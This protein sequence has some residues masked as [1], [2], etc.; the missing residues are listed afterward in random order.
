[1]TRKQL[2]TKA[3]LAEEVDRYDEVL[4]SMKKMALLK[5]D[6]TE[7]ERKLLKSAYRK[8]FEMRSYLLRRIS[9][10]EDY[11]LHKNSSDQAENL[12]TIRNYRNKMEKELK[13]LIFDFLIVLDNHLIQSTTLDK[14]K[15]FYYK[16]QG[17]C[18]KNLAEFSTGK[19]MKEA[20]KNSLMSYKAAYKAANKWLDTL[21]EESYK[22]ATLIQQLFADN[23]ILK[24][25]K[26]QGSDQ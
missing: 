19:D 22:N 12:I 2:F 7:E 15:V 9:R 14:S 24:N 1:M 4:E 17:D 6:L 10:F 21:P 20:V 23:Q 11:E 16:M 18:F 25:W 13:N 8:G 5:F 3:T 26:I